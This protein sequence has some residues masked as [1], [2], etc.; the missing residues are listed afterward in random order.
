MTEQERDEMMHRNWVAQMNGMGFDASGYMLDTQHPIRLVEEREP[1]A[2]VIESIIMQ[3]KE[4]TDEFIFE[5]VHPY[6]EQVTQCKISKRILERALIE[7]FQNHP[8][9]RNR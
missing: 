2:P 8:E 1:V 7:Y 3:A 6:C 5:T 4:K 9:E